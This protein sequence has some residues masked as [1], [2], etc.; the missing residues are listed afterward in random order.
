MRSHNKKSSLQAIPFVI[1][2]KLEVLVVLRLSAPSRDRIRLA[3]WSEVA[4]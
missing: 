4:F 3:I 2:N 1:F